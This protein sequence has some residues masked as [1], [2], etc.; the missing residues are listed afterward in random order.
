MENKNENKVN[1]LKVRMTG[2]Q[3]REIHD[4]CLITGYPNIQDFILI[5]VKREAARLL[6][7]SEAIRLKYNWDNKRNGWAR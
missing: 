6:T 7:Q 3:M 2:K 1:V 5:A 4:I